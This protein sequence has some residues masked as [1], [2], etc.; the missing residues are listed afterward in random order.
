MTASVH[1][2]PSRERPAPGAVRPRP[3]EDAPEPA[4]VVVPEAARFEGLLSFRGRARVDGEIEG[5]IVCRGTFV[6]G[7]TG[8]I[9]GT[10]EADEVVV[11]GRV[12]GDVTARGRI[13]LAPTARVQGTL[14]A[15]RIH[16]ADGCVLEGRCETGAP[17]AD[18]A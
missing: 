6:I 1:P 5:E 10:I 16:L 11:A 17:A 7:A 14:R 12:E 3:A 8:R 13:E 2:Q 18:R 15:P 9:V 4:P